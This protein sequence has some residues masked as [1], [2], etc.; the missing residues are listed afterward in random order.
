MIHQPLNEG[1]EELISLNSIF[2]LRGIEYLP[3]GFLELE[4]LLYKDEFY[5]KND[6]EEKQFK[7]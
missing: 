1:G 5:F 3:E 4:P 6:Y 2:K 7:E